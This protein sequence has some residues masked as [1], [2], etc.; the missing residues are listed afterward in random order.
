MSSNYLEFAQILTENFMP[1]GGSSI[2]LAGSNTA[3]NPKPISY[4]FGGSADTSG[5]TWALTSGV[6]A[7]Q[8]DQTYYSGRAFTFDVDLGELKRPTNLLF[9][10][11]SPSVGLSVSEF[12]QG[13]VEC[14]ID[15][16]FPSSQDQTTYS[17]D[18]IFY[19]RRPAED[20]FYFFL[21]RNRSYRYFRMKLFNPSGFS[22]PS[23]TLQL[24]DIYLGDSLDIDRSPTPGMSYQSTDSS[25]VY[26]SESGREYFHER[27]IVQGITTL[28]FDNLQRYQATS[29]K[30]WSDNIGITTPF[31]VI[32]DPWGGWDAPA[33]GASFGVYRLESMPSFSAEFPNGWSA[34]LV[35]KEYI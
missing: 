17:I 30:A 1:H 20:Y 21:S 31:W 9:R 15:S 35:L 10:W 27:S 5:S 2:K 29:I 13:I 6:K 22:S 4:K 16:P 28:V 19:S 25:E 7:T 14:R 26:V 3:L 34:S 23:S 18:D 32:L 33:Y 12:W 11:G 24:W 8:I